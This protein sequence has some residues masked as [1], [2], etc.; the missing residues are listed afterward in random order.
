MVF[1]GLALHLYLLKLFL[2][3]F[4]NQ[5][6]SPFVLYLYRFLHQDLVPFDNVVF[7]FGG[8]DRPIHRL[9]IVLPSKW[10]N[11]LLVSVEVVLRLVLSNVVLDIDEPVG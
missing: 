4:I 2:S 10:I 8:D 3:T 7:D 1:Q 6:N 11:R 5:F 9:R